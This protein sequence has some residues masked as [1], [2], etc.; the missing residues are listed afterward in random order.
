MNSNYGN[1]SIKELLLLDKR[2]KSEQNLKVQK[3]IEAV[4]NK[5]NYEWLTLRVNN[6]ATIVEE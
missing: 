3:T 6:D 5:K 2:K 4:I 1:C